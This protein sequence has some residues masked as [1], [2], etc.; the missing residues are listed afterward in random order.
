M[1]EVH[2]NARKSRSL[3]IKVL[4]ES[5]GER[6]MQNFLTKTI[7]RL[8]PVPP[9][10]QCNDMPCCLVGTSINVS[11]DHTTDDNVLL[12]YVVYR[13]WGETANDIVGNSIESGLVITQ[14]VR[15]SN[16]DL[17]DPKLIAQ[18]IEANPPPSGVKVV[19]I[20][21]TSEEY[22]AKLW[23]EVVSE[24]R[25]WMGGEG[26]GSNIHPMSLYCSESNAVWYTQECSL[27]FQ[28]DAS[29]LSD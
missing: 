16:K 17:L 9:G 1:I 22:A 6:D 24:N 19:G 26:G 7:G 28:W 13:A 5:V 15:N 18:T 25:S 23:A 4:A 29:A 20:S 8:Y 14:E 10:N 21:G 2:T 27:E 11:S 3:V 12:V